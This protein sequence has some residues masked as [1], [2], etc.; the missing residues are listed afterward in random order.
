MKITLIL[1]KKKTQLFMNSCNNISLRNTDTKN[2]GMSFT[3]QGK[4]IIEIVVDKIKICSINDFGKLYKE[5]VK[6]TSI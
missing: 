3:L 4:N 1:F 5:Y 6:S 2:K